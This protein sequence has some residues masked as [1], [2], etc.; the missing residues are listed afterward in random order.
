MQSG[1]ID[2]EGVGFAER[3]RGIASI[4]ILLRILRKAS[5][6]FEGDDFETVVILLTVAAASTGRY[7]RDY[8]VL[9]ALG[10]DPLPGDLHRPTSGRS[11]AD[12]TGLPRETVRRRLQGLVA[13]GRILKDERGFRTVSGGMMMDRNMEF[14]R[15]V[16][17]E[18]NGASQK[19]A[20]F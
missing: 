14:V 8:G 16:T 3:A 19:L 18:L 2:P 6:C 17:A 15:F 9:E 13:D 12:S 10:T 1:D 7:L 20:R 5:D 11:I 4:E